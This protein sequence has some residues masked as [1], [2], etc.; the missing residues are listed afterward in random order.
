MNSYAEVPIKPTG[1]FGKIQQTNPAVFGPDAWRSRGSVYTT[2]CVNNGRAGACLP[3]PQYGKLPDGYLFRID[4][5]SVP[6]RVVSET[7]HAGFMCKGTLSL[8][9]RRMVTILGLLVRV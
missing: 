9:K 4:V 1:L 5:P 8:S 7:G 6:S 3:N 2:R